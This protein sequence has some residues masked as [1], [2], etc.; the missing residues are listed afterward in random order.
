MTH[1]D[2]VREFSEKFG[3]PVADRPRLDV[4][5]ARRRY[6]HLAEEM[7]ELFRATN[8]G[9]LPGVA[10]ALADLVYVAL[11][12]ALELG[13]PFDEVFD[14]V[15]RSNMRKERRDGGGG[16][17]LGIGKPEGWRPPDVR[18]VLARHGWEGK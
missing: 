16:H 12:A 11:G 6:D 2:D 4:A 7:G 9:D 3:V 10:D 5:V 17:K 8:Q 1:F 13:V 14:E 18:G 15:H